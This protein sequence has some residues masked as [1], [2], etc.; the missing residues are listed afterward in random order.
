M[1]FAR[2]KKFY[3]AGYWTKEMVADGVVAVVITPEQYEEIADEV[4]VAV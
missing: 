1:W 2:I 3:D 4:Y